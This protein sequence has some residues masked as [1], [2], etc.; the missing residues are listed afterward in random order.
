MRCVNAVTVVD[1]PDADLLQRLRPSSQCFA[2][3]QSRCLMDQRMIN[4]MNATLD[5][6]TVTSLILAHLDAGK[7]KTF[8]EF[9]L[10][11]HPFSS[12]H[13]KAQSHRVMLCLNQQLVQKFSRHAL[14]CLHAI[15]QSLVHI[16]EAN[17]HLSEYRRS[18]CLCLK[19]FS[20]FA[21]F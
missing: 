12:C 2:P 6:S 20:S 16:P 5:S 7:N 11:V 18:S 8:G 13:T 15:H 1:R 3:K 4:Q 10:F 9:G 21:C 14:K 17:G 19:Y